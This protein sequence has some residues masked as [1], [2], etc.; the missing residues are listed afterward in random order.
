[1][2]NLT[3]ENPYTYVDSRGDEYSFYIT[4]N[5]KIDQYFNIKIVFRDPK[6]T[7]SIF[8]YEVISHS[9]AFP[10]NNEIIMWDA[11]KKY[12]NFSPRSQ[13]MSEEAIKMAN[14]IFKLK[15][16]L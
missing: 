10:L 4:T 1:M 11:Y 8:G 14:K 9:F 5:R 12:N 6:R 16:F 3:F 7:I 13:S 15:A 2:F